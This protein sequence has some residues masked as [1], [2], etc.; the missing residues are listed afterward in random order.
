M[1]NNEILVAEMIYALKTK[2]A[3]RTAAERTDSKVD[4]AILI[5]NAIELLKEK[6]YS[7]NHGAADRLGQETKNFLTQI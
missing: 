7:N 3:A 5:D 4:A 2:S 1:N 6:V